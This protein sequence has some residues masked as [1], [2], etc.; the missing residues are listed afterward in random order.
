MIANQSNPIL[1]TVD[2]MRRVTERH[3]LILDSHGLTARTGEYH[4]CP[5][6]KL[7]KEN[8]HNRGE[9]DTL[10]E[11]FFSIWQD[12][13]GRL[14]YNIHA[15]KLRHFTKYK[16]QSREFASA[17]RSKFNP[18]GWPNVSLKYGPLT[19]MQGWIDIESEIDDLIKNFISLHSIIDELLE[20]RK[21]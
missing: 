8:W 1:M 5:F 9:V 6:I 16:I 2:S 10:A 17:F 20:A 12:L 7:D 18:V 4:G 15:F 11:I 19:L 3:K 21:K 13:D 14:N